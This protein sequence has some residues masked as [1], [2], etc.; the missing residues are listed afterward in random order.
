MVDYVNKVGFDILIFQV[1]WRDGVKNL[2]PL[3]RLKCNKIAYFDGGVYSL[4]NVLKLIRGFGLQ[5]S[6]PYLLESL[7]PKRLI[8]R[9][10]KRR[11]FSQVVGLT[12]LTSDR[13]RAAGFLNSKTIYPGNDCAITNGS[14]KENFNGKYFLFT[15]SPHPARGAVQLLKAFDSFAERVSDAKLILLMRTD[16]GSD[17]SNFEQTLDG[18]RHRD[19]VSIIRK[20]LSREELMDY[21]SNAWS[22][23]LPFL[24]IPSEIPLTFFEVLSTGTP[25]ISF[26]NG[27]TTRYLSDALAISKRV[28]ADSLATTMER[29][30]NDEEFRN[31][32]SQN[33]VRLMGA[34][35][36]WEQ[37]GN[38]WL[39]TIT[40]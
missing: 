29:V 5:T 2:R 14:V 24:I 13:A 18:L 3:S 37:S 40:A 4:S 33:A 31:E 32:L 25:V 11:G 7:I 26:R 28:N 15:G 10:L 23:I 19:C 39:K 21:F 35:P 1:K 9:K 38:E 16:V 8:I 12:D 17:F 20:N 36:T 27:G 6:R 22:I 30:W 34:H